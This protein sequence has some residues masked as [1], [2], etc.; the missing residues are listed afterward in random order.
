[1][2]MSAVV[3]IFGWWKEGRHHRSPSVTGVGQMLQRNLF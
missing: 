2:Q 3:G 1:M